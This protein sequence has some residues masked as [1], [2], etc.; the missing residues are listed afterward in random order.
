MRKIVYIV[1]LPVILLVGCVFSKTISGND[2][3]SRFDSGIAEEN[4]FF[5]K[6]YES[7]ARPFTFQIDKLSMNSNVIRIRGSITD[8]INQ[9]AVPYPCLYLVS[10]DSLKYRIDKELCIGDILGNIDCCFE[11][12]NQTSNL[13]IAVSAI[14]YCGAV[15]VINSQP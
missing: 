13:L 3:I 11:W 2:I 14:G 4:G 6:R 12:D 8:D 5:V 10:D 1:M 15:Y 7:G 9:D